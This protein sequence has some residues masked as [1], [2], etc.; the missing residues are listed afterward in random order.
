MC[1]EKVPSSSYP[2]RPKITS[3]RTVAVTRGL[4]RVGEQRGSIRNKS[5]APCSSERRRRLK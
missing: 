5:P 4:Q 3:P 1:K 2:Q